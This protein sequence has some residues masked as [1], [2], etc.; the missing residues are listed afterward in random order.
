[1]KLLCLSAV[2]ALLLLALAVNSEKTKGKLWKEDKETLKGLEEFEAENEIDRKSQSMQVFSTYMYTQVKTWF[3][4]GMTANG[5]HTS[6]WSSSFMS[7]WTSSIVS[8][9]TQ[10]GHD[11]EETYHTD[12]D[13]EINW[14]TSTSTISWEV[15]GEN[16]WSETFDINQCGCG[17]NEVESHQ[18]SIQLLGRWMQATVDF[19]KQISD[20]YLANKVVGRGWLLKAFD[21]LNGLFAQWTT[22]VESLTSFYIK[23]G[24]N[25]FQVTYKSQI[26]SRLN[27]LLSQERTAIQARLEEG[28]QVLV[29]L[30]NPN[31]YRAQINL[32][33]NY[34]SQFQ[35]SYSL[36]LSNKWQM[37]ETAQAN[38]FFAGLHRPV[39]T[40]WTARRTALS[41]WWSDYQVIINKAYRY[42]VQMMKVWSSAIRAR[43]FGV[44]LRVGRAE[45]STVIGL[46]RARILLVHQQLMARAYLSFDRWTIGFVGWRVDIGFRQWMGTLSASLEQ[47]ALTLIQRLQV[48]Y[49]SGWTIVIRRPQ[50]R[51]QPQPQPCR[52]LFGLVRSVLGGCH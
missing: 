11:D 14:E 44:F 9:F 45:W 8:S 41:W 25:K 42:Y 46:Y 33:V 6:V 31:S 21:S 28:R 26:E 16:S 48:H 13:S 22:F 24:S 27:A 20:W 37:Y 10:A 4:S 34:R 49:R 30:K 35:N 50:P 29:W 51:P 18:W 7:T 2:G 43:G 52:G 38:A 19:R 39:F 1:M 17:E 3:Q 15:T 23:L 12:S 5:A 32:I 47:Y 36:I 40:W